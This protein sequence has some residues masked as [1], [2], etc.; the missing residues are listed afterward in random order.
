MCGNIGTFCSLLFDLLQDFQ[1]EMLTLPGQIFSTQKI[2]PRSG[3]KA[4]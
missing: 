2:Y 4:K 1:G 3:K